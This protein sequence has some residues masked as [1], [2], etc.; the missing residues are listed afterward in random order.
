MDLLLNKSKR[1]SITNKQTNKNWMLQEETERR[2]T[3]EH[4]ETF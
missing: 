3:L 2:T 1:T 4:K